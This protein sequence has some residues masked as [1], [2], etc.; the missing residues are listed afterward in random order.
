M[1]KQVGKIYLLVRPKK[2]KSIET[3]IEDLT[4]NPVSNILTREKKLPSQLILHVNVIF[5]IK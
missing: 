4:R 2:G 1:L 5:F 3:R